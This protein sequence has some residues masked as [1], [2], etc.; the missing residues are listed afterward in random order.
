MIAFL[1][2][3][4][5]GRRVPSGGE[6]RPRRSGPAG[7]QQQPPEPVIALGAGGG[8]L[9]GAAE[10]CLRPG[11]IALRL[12]DTSLNQQ[13]LGSGRQA[14]PSALQRTGSGDAV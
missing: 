11:S 7:L 8:Q 9:Q 2:V 4:N 1:T 3:V 13:A 6:D 5:E 12:Q 10:G 14:S